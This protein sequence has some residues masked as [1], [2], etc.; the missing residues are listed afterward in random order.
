MHLAR[1]RSLKYKHI[2]TSQMQSLRNDHSQKHQRVTLMMP[3]LQKNFTSNS[4]RDTLTVKEKELVFRLNK[5]WLRKLEFKKL[6]RDHKMFTKSDICITIFKI[7]GKKQKLFWISNINRNF[8]IRKLSKLPQIMS[9]L[10]VKASL[11]DQSLKI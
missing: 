11:Q 9:S 7:K 5:P 2:T 3:M 4:T 1:S 10:K 8:Q 6:S